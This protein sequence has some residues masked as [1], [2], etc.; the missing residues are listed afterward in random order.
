VA[1]ELEL[2]ESP[3]VGVVIQDLDTK[4]CSVCLKC[5]LGKER[6]VSLGRFLQVDKRQAAEVIHKYSSHLVAFLEEVA[7]ILAHKAC[8]R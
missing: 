8:G 4:G 3:V 6:L 7:L 5:S 1:Q 2:S